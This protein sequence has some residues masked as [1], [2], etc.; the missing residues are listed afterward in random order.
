MPVTAFYASVLALLFILLSARVIRHRRS[1]KVAVGDGGDVMLLRHMRVHA[2]FAE[3]VPLALLLM[4]LAESLHT[5]AWF[6]HLLGLALL[7]GRTLHA[8]GL[9]QR[10]ETFQFRVA[11]MM[12]TFAVT[13]GAAAA[14][15]FGSIMRLL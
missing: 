8:Y 6:L 2:N 7:A 10:R 12:A 4:A 9:S 13:A 3:Y 1:A 14:C 5:W 11:G 15:L